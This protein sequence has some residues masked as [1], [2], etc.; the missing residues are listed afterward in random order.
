MP[1]SFL[2]YHSHLLQLCT[3][4]SVCHITS[5]WLSLETLFSHDAYLH[6]AVHIERGKCLGDCF[7]A[8]GCPFLHKNNPAYNPGTLAPWCTSACDGARQ[9]IVSQCWEKAGM[10]YKLLD[11]AQSC[12]FPVTQRSAARWLAA[13]SDILINVSLT[14]DLV[15]IMMLICM[16][17]V[18]VCFMILVI[19]MAT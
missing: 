10:Y 6:S 5:S 7:Y 16:V 19:T 4:L 13:R 8:G 1:L 2:P 11:T 18:S 15:M 14:F 9:H 17:L 3:S 12:H